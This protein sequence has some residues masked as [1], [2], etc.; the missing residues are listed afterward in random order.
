MSRWN[1]LIES[2]EDDARDRFLAY[3]MSLPAR[4]RDFAMRW[5]ITYKVEF[6][7]DEDL[8]V[9]AHCLVDGEPRAILTHETREEAAE[10][11]LENCHQWRVNEEGMSNAEREY[12]ANRRMN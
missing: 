7:D 12:V 3:M 6:A 11:G 8:N 4:L 2:L 10:K 9:V 1:D 5:P